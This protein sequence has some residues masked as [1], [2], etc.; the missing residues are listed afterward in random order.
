MTDLNEFRSLGLSEETLKAIHAKGFET[1]SPIQALTIP[2]LLANQ[3]DIIGQ[4]QTG[5]GKTAAFGLPILEQITPGSGNIQALILV[6]TRELALQVTDELYSFKTRKTVITSIYGGASI[7]EQLRRLE[8]GVDI[9]VGTPGRVL[10]MI[11]RG[12]LRLEHIRWMVLDEADEMLNMGFIEDVEEI[13]SHTNAERRTLLFSATMPSRIADLSKRFMRDVQLL[14]VE[15]K[16]LITDLTDQIYFE[17]REGDKFDAL[18]RIIDIENDFYAIIFCRTKVMVDEVTGRLLERGY[19][20]DALHGDVSQAQREKI[21]AKFKRKQINILVATDVAA[22]GID[23]N[24]L[25]HVI[26]YSLPQDSESYVHRIGRTGRAGNQGTAITF[27]SNAEYRQFLA[28]KRQVK[29]EIRKEE[30]PSVSDVISMKRQAILSDLNDMIESG[31]YDEYSEMAQEI[32][33]A[34]KPE[35]ALAA[36]LKM[37]FKNDL[38]ASSY[39][40]IRKFSVDRKGKA[41]LFIA[42]GR[43]DDFSP[44]SLVDFIRKETGLSSSQI[45]DVKILDEFSFITVPY[46]VSEKVVQGLNK[47][48]TNGRPLAEITKNAP[49]G[50]SDRP[51]RGGSRE[52]FERKG[53]SREVSGKREYKRKE[54]APAQGSTRRAAPAGRD[55]RKR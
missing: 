24:N 20:A 44:R 19:A 22:R 17:V 26:N 21:L 42:V 4:A 18:T 53:R 51:R 28:M 35:V 38:D 16:N 10:D 46:E 13:L 1:P 6:P 32:L 15:N 47:L 5:T 12:A 45:D 8:K 43:R 54:Y 39:S 27:I 33:T 11:R 23:V 36:L 7:G 31:V 48:S 34:N 52:G 2:V 37:A 50:G 9:V 41:R 3:N 40:E 29:A 14:K 30:I 49:G 25:T 55:R